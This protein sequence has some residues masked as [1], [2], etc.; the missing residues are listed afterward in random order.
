[1]RQ[2]IR[3]LQL[4][5]S[6][7][8]YGTESVII[9]L[10][11]ALSKT[12]YEPVIGCM[13][14]KHGAKPL[15]GDTAE[16]C[17]LKTR[18]FPMKYKF[19][20][21]TVRQI[22][23]MIKE[24]GVR[25]IHCH[26]Y[27]SNLFGLICAKMT[28][29][30]IVT[31]NHLFPPMPLDDKK[32]Q[33]YSKL[34]AHYTMKRLDKVVA[35]SEDIKAKLAHTGIHH[36]KIKVIENGIDLEPLQRGSEAKRTGARRSLGIQ[37]GSFVIGTLGRLTPQ[38]AHGVLLEATK[39]LLE[40]NSLLTVI[41]AGDGPLEAQLKTYAEQLNIS[42]VVKFLGFRKN[43]AELLQAM[44][45]FVLSSVDEGLPMALLEA[46]AMKVPAIATEVGDVPKVIRNMETGILIKPNDATMLAEG[47]AYLIDNNEHRAVMAANAYENVRQYHS[48]EAM[49]AKYCEV[50]DE[51]MH[52]SR[53]HKQ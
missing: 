31:T 25:L 4:H 24:S 29:I 11:K 22:V 6:A 45:L 33:M 12:D 13:T 26:G 28:G 17:D 21:L 51:V 3:L 8:M 42:H 44:D 16:T 46:M 41:I 27:K 43:I 23:T 32:L 47:F 14:K 38:K 36:T 35:V 1:M 40:K 49:C 30:S 10:C 53:H 2:S 18:Y 19:D 34:D 15:L 9:N 20:P 5:D 48:K 7:G 39:Q 50:Y 37:E 52:T